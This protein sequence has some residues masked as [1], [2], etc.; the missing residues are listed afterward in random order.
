MKKEVSMM[1]NGK[2]VKDKDMVY[3]LI[4]MATYMRVIGSIIYKMDMV[5]IPLYVV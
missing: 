3:G 5:H 2:I 4:I 1:D